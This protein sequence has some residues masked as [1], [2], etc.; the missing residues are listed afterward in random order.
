MSN[1]ETVETFNSFVE[2]LQDRDLADSLAKWRVKILNCTASIAFMTKLEEL[3]ILCDLIKNLVEVNVNYKKELYRYN[4]HIYEISFF[5]GELV[6]VKSISIDTK[7][8]K[9]FWAMKVNLEPIKKASL[10]SMVF[11]EVHQ[12]KSDFLYKFYS[13]KN[14]YKILEK[15]S[16]VVSSVGELPTVRKVTKRVPIQLIR[17]VPCVID[18]DSPEIQLADKTKSFELSVIC[19]DLVQKLIGILSEPA[20]LVL[21]KMVEDPKASN[22]SIRNDCKLNNYTISIAKAEIARKAQELCDGVDVLNIY[23]AYFNAGEVC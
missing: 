15:E 2:G 1:R 19:N 23:P 5:D 7:L 4:K 8:V 22:V 10:S 18:G 20:K 16:V 21:R 3:D 13:S 17:E 14:G 11:R 12:F 6:E 9:S